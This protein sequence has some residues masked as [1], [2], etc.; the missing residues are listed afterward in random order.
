MNSVNSDFIV[1]TPIVILSLHSLLHGLRSDNLLHL[2]AVGHLS[3]Y[4]GSC[5]WYFY[6]ITRFKAL[7]L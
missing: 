3:L 1:N 2:G 7:Y 6:H 4:S 5:G